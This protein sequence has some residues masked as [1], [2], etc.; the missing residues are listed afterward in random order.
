[1]STSQY[2]PLRVGERMVYVLTVLGRP[3]GQLTQSVL[4]VRQ[5]RGAVLARMQ[6]HLSGQAPEHYAVAVAADEVRV[7]NQVALL[8]PLATGRAWLGGTHDEPARLTVTDT[9][10]VVA[11]PA[12]TYPGCVVVTTRRAGAEAGATWYAPGV[13]MVKHRFPVPGGWAELALAGR[14]P[15][16]T[17]KS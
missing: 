12:G 17:G 3:A 13:G 8:G 14:E 1:M 15:A 9:D 10:A 11:V 2:F 4:A 7:A 16:G 5:G 6:R